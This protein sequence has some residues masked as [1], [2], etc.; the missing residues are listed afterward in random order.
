[1]QV[2]WKTFASGR[3]SLHVSG[4]TLVLEPLGS[5]NYDDE[6]E[7]GLRD[8]IFAKKQEL[9][10]NAEARLAGV[11]AKAGWGARLGSFLAGSFMARIVRNLSV[12]VENI[13][14][15]WLQAEHAQTSPLQSPASA[16][17]YRTPSP[18]AVG[19][20]LRR[21]ALAPTACASTTTPA[22]DVS[23]SPTRGGRGSTGGGGGGGGDGGGGGSG[24]SSPKARAKSGVPA[25]TPDTAAVK[26]D[27]E[28]DS[29]LA[30]TKESTADWLIGLPSSDSK[31][32]DEDR[33]KDWSEANHS[34]DG[35]RLR[36]VP[37]FQDL[38]AGMSGDATAD[39]TAA[40]TATRH[41]AAAVAASGPPML[42]KSEGDS[43]T[44]S[45]GDFRGDTTPI[46]IVR[47]LKARGTLLIRKPGVAAA[48]VLPA[49]EARGFDPTGGGDTSADRSGRANDS[50]GV[51]EP[52]P[53]VAVSLDV[54]EIALQVDVRQYAVMNAAVSALTMSHRRF[55]FRTMRP[56]TSVL[57]DPEA[58]WRYA[59]R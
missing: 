57:D 20:Y 24:V 1:L 8:A 17:T 34:D 49:V 5:A 36:P 4:L 51:V 40:A 28:L 50:G 26:K 38:A 46:C 15:V 3:A 9:L 44:T 6:I 10:A 39:V 43:G 12:S 22:D 13:H 32:G 48:A 47:P 52:P 14:V 58:W 42:A 25:A 53:L 31:D 35:R 33:G 54:E 41:A 55:K 2:P 56:T 21:L 27:I 19:I 11:R 16:E 45:A 7:R 18:S 37:P 30:Y 59:I 29:L 23:H